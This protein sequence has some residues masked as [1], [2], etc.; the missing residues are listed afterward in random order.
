MKNS[1]FFLGALTIGIIGGLF[2]CVEVPSGTGPGCINTDAVNYNPDAGWDDG[3]CVV[4]QE[5]SM[6][7][8]FQYAS[9]ADPD[10]NDV[11]F[12]SVMNANP[13]KVLGIRIPSFDAFSW[14]GNDS[15]LARFA[16]KYVPSGTLPEYGTNETYNG[17]AFINANANI[18]SQYGIAPEG[19]IGIYSSVGGGINAG[20]LNIDMYVKFFDPLSQYYAA[21]YVLHKTIV[22]PQ[23]VGGT[24]N[25]N[26]IHK[27]VAMASVTPVFGAPI[28]ASEVSAGNIYHKGYVFPY[29]NIPGFQ[30]DSYE[31]VGV[32][33][34]KTGPGM[35]KV[36]NVTPNN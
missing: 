35:F 2:S 28:P 32:L 20:K 18:V 24:P 23:N 22:E 6:S 8:F 29:T 3:S 13:G 36:V 27:H 7:L 5:K 26:F 10:C 9:T 25:P 33:W 11:D 31:V 14:G 15:I 30:I 17:T 21:V 4:I 34:R 16:S 19:G 12:N 1:G